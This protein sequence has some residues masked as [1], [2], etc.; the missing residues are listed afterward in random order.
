MLVM[1]KKKPKPRGRKPSGGRQG[2]QLNLYLPRDVR[3]CLGELAER[4]ARTITAE[5]VRAL[6]KHF[7]DEGVQ[8]PPGEKK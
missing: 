7:R 5:V 3:V 4:N 2:V 1:D 6:V 8:Y